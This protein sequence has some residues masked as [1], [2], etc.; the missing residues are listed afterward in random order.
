A[1]EPS[2]QSAS[3]PSAAEA[4][5]RSADERL[6][7][8]C[9]PDRRAW[10]TAC[11]AC[12]EDGGPV[13]DPLPAVEPRWRESPPLSLPQTPEQTARLML[14]ASL[15]AADPATLEQILAGIR[16]P[17]SAADR[18]RMRRLLDPLFQPSAA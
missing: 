17:L 14:K 12:L 5:R 10:L 6:A 8:E 13:P 15:Q 16:R 9:D 7:T 4:V 1:P 3:A 11:R 2:P 18:P